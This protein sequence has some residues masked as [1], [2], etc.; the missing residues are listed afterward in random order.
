M[1]VAGQR[2]LSACRLPPSAIDRLYGYA[3]VSEYLLPNGLFKVHSELGLS[4]R[5]AVIPVDDGFTNFITGAVLGWEAIVA[6][7]CRHVM[8]NCGSGWTRNADYEV[9]Y[10]LVLGDGAGAAERQPP[11]PRCSLPCSLTRKGRSSP[12]LARDGVAI[13]R[14]WPEKQGILGDLRARRGRAA[15]QR[16]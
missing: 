2:A 10:S 6:G 5:A 14:A 15:P 8:I 11:Q 7:R 16:P 4:S 12:A 9:D 13:E 1:V 3:S